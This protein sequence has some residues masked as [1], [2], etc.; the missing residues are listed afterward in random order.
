MDN[1]LIVDGGVAK[2]IR[3]DVVHPMNK[4]ILRIV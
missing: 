3:F 4:Y 1:G 2:E